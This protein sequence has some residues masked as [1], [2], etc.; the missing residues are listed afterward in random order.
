MGEG[1]RSGMGECGWMVYRG[2]RGKGGNMEN[3]K[4]EGGWVGCGGVS[5]GCDEE[6]GGEWKCGGG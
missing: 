4:G 3:C 2:W 6:G 1:T 5:E